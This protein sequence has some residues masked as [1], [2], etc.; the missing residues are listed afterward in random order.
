FRMFRVHQNARLLNT[1]LRCE[2]YVFGDGKIPSIS[3]SASIDSEN[4]MHVTL[5]NLNPNK[6]I[7]ITCPVIGET[8]KNISGEV[9]TAN[10]MN[11]M[12]TFDKPD[13][14]KP[15]AFNGFS[16]KNGILTINMPS[17]SVVVLEL[18]K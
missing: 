9:L 7:T 10:A 17:K 11:A 5:A 2:D 18:T 12:N 14:V 16:Y 13:N 4:K 3:A 1:D 15:V 8:Y 6:S